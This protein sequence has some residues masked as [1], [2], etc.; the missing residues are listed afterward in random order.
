[1]QSLPPPAPEWYEDAR[2]NAAFTSLRAALEPWFGEARSLFQRRQFAEAF[3]AYEAL[4]KFCQQEDEYGRTV[5]FPENLELAEEKARYLRACLESGLPAHHAR[6][7]LAVWAGIRAGFPA[8]PLAAVLEIDPQPLAGR[9]ALLE[10][11]IKA[12]AVL[13]DDL[14]DTWLREAVYLRHG[15]DGLESWV[16]KHG[17]R[18]PQ[19]WVYWVSLVARKKEPGLTLEAAN[20]ALHHLPSRW[21]IRAELAEFALGAA[22]ELGRPDLARE[23]QWEAFCATRAAPDVA[24]LFNALDD[25]GERQAWMR[26]VLQELQSPIPE[27]EAL[28]RAR[29]SLH[30][31]PPPRPDPAWPF[32]EDDGTHLYGLSAWHHYPQTQPYVTALTRL[33]AGDWPTAWQEARREASIGW[34]RLEQTQGLL[35]AALFA[36]IVR[37]TPTDVLPP[38]VEALYAAA[39][40]AA[41]TP[42]VRG[43]L[44]QSTPIREALDAAMARWELDP[45]TCDQAIQAAIDRVDAI[46]G[47]GLRDAYAKAAQALRAAM[48][49]LEA[50]GRPMEAR[51]LLEQITARHAR[52]SAFKRELAQC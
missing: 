27:V 34:S 26:R 22:H 46:A 12:L 50:L 38:A 16:E 19:A 31:A 8:L 4:F 17:D 33:L 37:K 13:A 29:D 25:S 23:A 5:G 51:L 6:R 32:R 44:P 1:M 42:F 21:C 30:T 49:I 2:A 9:E 15:L 28:R 48:E 11:L 36:R 3:Q 39:L 45:A 24:R 20:K 52:K 40:N 35:V 18:R 41:S 47:A 7:L 10:A 14:C 43:A